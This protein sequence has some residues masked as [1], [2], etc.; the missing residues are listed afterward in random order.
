MTS[1]I[2]NSLDTYNGIAAPQYNVISYTWGNFVDPAAIGLSVNGIDWPVPAVGKGH[3]TADTFKTAIER[4]ANGIKHR[5]EWLWVDIACI[6]QHH[7]KETKEA[8]YMRGQEI[9]RQ[10]E[11]FQRACEAFAWV[12][13]LSTSELSKH[14][15]LV[16]IDDFL[17]HANQISSIRDTKALVSYLDTCD[18]ISC[19]LEAW[20]TKFFSHPWFSSLWTLQEMMLRKDAWILFDD[21]FVDLYPN[22]N[23][24]FYP[25]NF[26]TIKN[27]LF[28]IR[29]IHGG[30][31]MTAMKKLVAR[32]QSRAFQ[33][34]YKEYAERI[35]QRFGKLLKVHDYKGL[36]VLSI[37]TVHGAYSVAQRRN[38]SRLTDRIYGIVQTYGIS[39]NPDPI[40]K[41]DL[42]K[43][44]TLEDE[45]GTK[46]VAKSALLSQL[47]IHDIQ[48]APR[49]SWLI[50]QNCT[51][52]SFWERFSPSDRVLNELASISV[53]EDTKNMRFSGK[54]WCLDAFTIS[55]DDSLFHPNSRWPSN[56][57]G[58]MLDRHVSEEVLGQAV[59]Y[60]KSHEA[61]RRAVEK[62]REHYGKYV[63]VALLGSASPA[64]LPAVDYVGL[65][66]APLDSHA[67]SSK[68]IRLGLVRWAEFY[69]VEPIQLHYHLPAS[70]D[71]QCEIV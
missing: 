14:W 11:I 22:G 44:R 13:H 61:M 23:T 20:L 24:K 4:A 27:D 6:P 62:L 32:H 57:L 3:F 45:F 1:Y 26:I 9:G 52:D 12:S 5:C 43:L 48:K 2:R 67:Q 49:R 64:D 55:R 15:P 25:W 33:E 29:A 63:R 46:L 51:V 56:Y 41:D 70:H 38:A 50:T 30:R 7:E 68:W 47:F 18:D 31:V 39:C 28:A 54:V 65:V 66:L 71:F 60:F 16:T 10:V 19:L 34:K 40:G 21:G 35:D 59:D 36:E 8:R 58:P 17:E 53:V 69:H 37:G 42:A